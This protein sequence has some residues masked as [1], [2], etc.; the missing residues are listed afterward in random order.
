M[1]T[2]ESQTKGGWAG[3]GE[4]LLTN[5]PQQQA[6]IA[7]I[8]SR[9]KR[10]WLCWSAWCWRKGL[11]EQKPLS[12]DPG[13]LCPNGSPDRAWLDLQGVST[14]SAHLPWKARQEYVIATVESDIREL[15]PLRQKQF[16]CVPKWLIRSCF[17]T[18][19]LYWKGMSW[20]IWQG[21]NL[22]LLYSLLCKAVHRVNDS[23]ALIAY[24]WRYAETHFSD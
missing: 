13:P 10:A 11:L 2:F 17:K 8:L 14:K 23:L 4:A 9:R 19:S 20:W 18:V 21:H 5:L 12:S 16:I 3:L 15:N 7:P 24:I 22:V 1:Q 6:I